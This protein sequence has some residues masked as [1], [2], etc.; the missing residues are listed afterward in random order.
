[1]KIIAIKDMAAGNETV[2]EAWKETKI[3]K[4][5]DTLLDV[6]NWVGLNKNVT[7]SVPDNSTEDFL[8]QQNPYD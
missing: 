4:A 3:F 5:T 2:G 6:M 7:I 8:S 1:M